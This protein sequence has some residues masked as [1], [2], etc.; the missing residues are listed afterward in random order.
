MNRFITAFILSAFT[1]ASC[2]P[3]YKIEGESSISYLDGKMLFL[4][5]F[6]HDRFTTID[7]AEVVHGFFNM[8]GHIDSTQMA[9]LFMDDMPVMP[10]VLEKGGIRVII[11]NTEIRAKGTP[12][13]DSL[14]NFFDRKNQIDL[15]MTEL[16]RKEAKMI[17]DGGDID[18]I[19]TA[20]HQ[21]AQAVN[22]EMKQLIKSFLAQNSDNVLGPGVFLILCQSSSPA[23]M[24]Q[25]EEMIAEM[26][27]S[28]KSNPAIKDCLSQLQRPE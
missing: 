21:E 8:K 23:M 24:P 13:N 9:M 14:Y 27:E 28:F 1:L 12:M 10:V 18:D 15:R 17:L 6:Q 16:K 3:K 26:P 5:Q 20:L 19:Q 7:S 11:N 25:I 4:R 22:E 2:S